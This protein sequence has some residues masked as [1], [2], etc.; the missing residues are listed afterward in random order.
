MPKRAATIPAKHESVKKW[1]TS[2]PARACYIAGHDGLELTAAGTFNYRYSAHGRQQRL[3]LGKFPGMSLATA[4]QKAMEARVKV[5]LGE[6]PK[7]GTKSGMTFRE[8]A[9]KHLASGTLKRST[10]SEYARMLAKDAYPLFGAKD[11]V[12]VTEDD[13]YAMLRRIEKRDSKRQAD[14]TKAAVAS[15]YKPLRKLGYVKRSP[16]RDIPNLYEPNPREHVATDDEI[17]TLWRDS[18]RLSVAVKLIIRLT[19]LTGLRRG[20]VCGALVSEVVGDRWTVPAGV[21]AK[22]RIVKEGRMKNSTEQT[23]FL[24]TQAQAFFAE[25]L[26]TCSDG[27]VFFESETIGGR[28]R[29]IHP[30]SVSRAVRRIRGAKSDARL[31][32]L[33]RAAETW[34]VEN[35]YIDAMTS[36]KMLHHKRQDVTGI[37]YDKAKHEAALT[38]AWQAWGNHVESIVV[39][40]SPLAT[41][42]GEPVPEAVA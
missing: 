19:I 33:R 2:P 30:E 1:L 10:T 8:V 32:D 41:V 28:T 21:K 27:H 38:R 7:A 18:E 6:D 31:H 16:T 35:G 29:H 14:I 3:L 23:V 15:V 25:A 26:K 12:A 4:I 37:H 5:G 39:A 11:V 42:S 36:G 17:R 24:S 34:C 9:E 13:I 40:A 22:S 20:E